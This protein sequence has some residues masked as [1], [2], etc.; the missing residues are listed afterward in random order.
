MFPWQECHN[1]LGWCYRVRTC[2]P[3]YA[4]YQTCLIVSVHMYLI[5]MCNNDISSCRGGLICL[6][7]VHFLLSCPKRQ[8]QASLSNTET[9]EGVRGLAE[10]T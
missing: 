10:S 8:A 3:V 2:L 1:V 9:G 6:F 7:G 4:M 5:C